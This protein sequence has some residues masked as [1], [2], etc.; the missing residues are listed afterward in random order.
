MPSTTL[1]KPVNLP[2][3]E[4]YAELYALLRQAHDEL[5]SFRYRVE[6]TLDEF[7]SS[8]VEPDP[9]PTLEEVGRLFSFVD[10]LT[11]SVDDM[12]TDV[13][14]LRACVGQLDAIRQTTELPRQLSR[15][16]GHA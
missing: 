6:T 9:L 4:G 8:E 13:E 14:R 16:S 10:G 11:F 3:D 1:S 2:T 7:E 5:E 15:D 12:S